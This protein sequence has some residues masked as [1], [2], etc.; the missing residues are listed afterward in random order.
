MTVLVVGGNGQLGAACCAELSRRQVPARASV[1]ATS[2]AGTLKNAGLDVDVVELDLLSGP[3]ARRRVLQDIECVILSANAVVPR[4]GDRPSEVDQAMLDLVDDAVAAGVRRV[5]LPSLPV[6]RADDAVP[7]ARS[8]R[9]LERHLMD[10]P[11]ES[12]VLWLPPFMESW[13]ALAGSSLPLRGEPHAT[14]GRPSPFLR[15]FRRVTGRLVEDRGRMLVPGPASHRHAFIA[16]ADAARACVEA[17]TRPDSPSEPVQVAGPEVL[18]WTDVADRFSAV[19]G[20]RVTV[21]TVPGAVFA[22]AARVL[23]PVAD[24]PSRTMALNHY[25]AAGETPWSPG[26]GGLVDPATMTTVAQFLQA[27]AALPDSAP[28]VL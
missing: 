15:R 4:G 25:V 21:M 12:W 28:D 14:I 18:T 9:R 1:R 7:Y 5:V 20:R 19:L 11:L 3:A 16:V 17:A 10:S 27:K 6:T 2:R 13:L 22:A 8:R 23:G 26:G 24:V